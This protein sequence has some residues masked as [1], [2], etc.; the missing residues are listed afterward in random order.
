VTTVQATERAEA[1]RRHEQMVLIRRFETK[2]DV[3]YRQGR[4][5]GGPRTWGWGRRR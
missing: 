2:I 1:L 5:G 3:L 4:V